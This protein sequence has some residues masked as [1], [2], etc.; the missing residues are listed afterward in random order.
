MLALLVSTW[1]LSATPHASQSWEKASLVSGTSIWDEPY[2]HVLIGR[3]P[4]A[5]AESERACK[6]VGGD[7]GKLAGTLFWTTAITATFVQGASLLPA[8]VAKEHGQQGFR[9]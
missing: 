9:C 3:G 4:T 7:V 6:R 5:D 8:C 2:Q 1:V